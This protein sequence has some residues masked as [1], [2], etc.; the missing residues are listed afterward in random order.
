MPATGKVLPTDGIV[1]LD[2]QSSEP[3]REPDSV[4]VPVIPA[5]GRQG[6]KDLGLD[7]RL[8]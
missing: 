5:S 1:P 7:W 3:Q 8:T 2:L 6:M 4:G